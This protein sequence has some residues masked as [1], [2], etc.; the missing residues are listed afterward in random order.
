MDNKYRLVLDDKV[1]DAPKSWFRMHFTKE[2]SLSDMYDTYFDDGRKCSWCNEPIKRNLK[3]YFDEATKE[4]SVIN[5]YEFFACRKEGCASLDANPRSYEWLKFGRGMT[6]EQAENFS[7]NIGQKSGSTL[8]KRRSVS[9]NKNVYSKQYWIDKGYTPEQAQYKVNS[10]NRRKKEFWLERGYLP[11]RAENMA[12]FHV[13]CNSKEFL[14][15]FK[16]YSENEADEYIDIH[17]KNLSFH[18]KN[19]VKMQ[20][21]LR[22]GSKEADVFFLECFDDVIS[23]FGVSEDEVYTES[24]GKG[25]EWFCRTNDGIFYYDFCIPSLNLVIEYHG[26]HVHPKN[27]VDT[28]WEHAYSKESSCSV[29]DRDEY[30]EKIIVDKFGFNN[31]YV[32]YS[33]EDKEDFKE[34][35]LN[36]I[37]EELERF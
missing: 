19:S 11:H 6:D 29:W 25:Q 13:C 14:M 31:Y 20:Q 5:K 7:K 23:H 18:S 37:G 10:R 21:G 9:G 15:W 24:F 26:T 16:G 3:F 22:K 28:G 2:M 4:V 17:L 34:R 36:N 30:K 32:F 12:K 27:R 1:Y 33:D 8:K 35:L